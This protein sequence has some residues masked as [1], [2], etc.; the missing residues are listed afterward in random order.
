MTSRMKVKTR[1]FISLVNGIIKRLLYKQRFFILFGQFGQLRVQRQ[2]WSVDLRAHWGEGTRKVK[3]LKSGVSVRSSHTHETQ[4]FYVRTIT[5]HSVSL[6]LQMTTAV[7]NVTV[8]NKLFRI[9]KQRDHLVSEKSN[10]YQYSGCCRVGEATLHTR[11][12]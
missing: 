1:V 5:F 2:R 3:E 10:A 8:K 7:W 11:L 9:L 4:R 12:I 6:V